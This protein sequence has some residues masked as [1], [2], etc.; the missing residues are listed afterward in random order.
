[1]N[2]QKYQAVLF[3][4]DGVLIDSM[5]AHANAWRTVFAEYGVDL[6][7]MEIMLREGEKAE[8]SLD[9]L[10]RKY[11]LALSSAEKTAMLIKKRQIY[12]E[13]APNTIVVG[14]AEV[15]QK[16][17]ESGYRMALVTGS[18]AKNLE[19][20]MTAKQLALFEVIVTGKDV[21]RAKPDPE[22]YL[23][24]LR[25]LGLQPEVCLVVENAPLGIQAAKSAGL[26][27]AAI[28]STLSREVLTE[29]DWIIGSLNEIKSILS[30]GDYD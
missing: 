8:F 29:A 28:T 4:L 6:P 1:M 2:N 19:R 30:F 23:K 14:A 24:A 7:R 16:I 27:V 18:V 9:E 26:K 3:D 22:P 5:S 17:H 13:N 25:K 11:G 21:K 10:C 20:I 15:L 12:A